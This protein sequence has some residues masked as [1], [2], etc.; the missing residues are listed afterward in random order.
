MVF[1]IR[2]DLHKLIRFGLTAV[3]LRLAIIECL[4]NRIK[5]MEYL[6]E[7]KQPRYFASINEFESFPSSTKVSS[8][9][10]KYKSSMERI[11]RSVEFFEIFMNFERKKV[12]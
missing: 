12:K 3:S 2:F 1:N 7:K 11:S 10:L 6:Q 8:F 4:Q 9:D 5:S